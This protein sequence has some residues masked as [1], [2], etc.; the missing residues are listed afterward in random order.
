[1]AVMLFNE[2]EGL[3]PTLAELLGA[4]RGLGISFELLIID[5]GSTD[6][7]GEL[8]S[9]LT[10]D[11]PEVRIVRH[12]ENRGLGEVYRTGFR[13]AR[14]QW[15]TFFPADGEV[16]ADCLAAFLQS[17]PEN[18]LLLGLIP[19]TKRPWPAVLLSFC[20]RSLYRLLFGAFPPFQGIFMIRTEEL[21]R[22]RL[23]SRGRSWVNLKELIIRATRRGCRYQSVPTS[24]RGRYGGVSKVR[25]LRIILLN[26]LEAFRLRAVMLREQLG[27]I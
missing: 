20:E 18:D 5:D 19:Q 17:M 22:H 8:A 27:L 3:Q 6:G 14:G 10:R 11:E 12:Q 25:N 24:L 16:P 13:Q 15:L 1:M 23:R 21:R 2:I 9:E 26:L 4:L 7:S